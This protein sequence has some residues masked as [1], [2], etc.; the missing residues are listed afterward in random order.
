[1]ITGKQYGQLKFLGQILLPAMG[2]SYFTYD[3]IWGVPNIEE[4]LGFI[5]VINLFLGILLGISQAKYN[6]E[7]ARGGVLMVTETDE[8][9]TFS[10]VLADDPDTLKTKKEVRFDIRKE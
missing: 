7:I 2:A 10:L 5:F 9:E 8:G 3:Q 1:M 4:V 6:Q